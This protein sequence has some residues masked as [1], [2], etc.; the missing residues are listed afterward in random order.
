[1]KAAVISGG[2]GRYEV[3]KV[4]D[5]FKSKL[6]RGTFLSIRGQFQSMNSSFAG[7]ALVSSL[8]SCSFT[9]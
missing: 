8:P 1:V 2:R 5:S 6:P 4:V 3:S 7:L 9:S